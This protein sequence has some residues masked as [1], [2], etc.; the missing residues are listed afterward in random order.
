MQNLIYIIRIA[1]SLLL[2]VLLG[3]CGDVAKSIEI[4][5]KT[6]DMPV[7]EVKIASLPVDYS[8]TGSVVS[9]QRIDVSSRATGYIRKILVLEGQQVSKGQTL[10][11]LDES[12]VEGAIREAETVV[13]TAKLV[14]QD[15]E[16]D[17]KRYSDLY[18]RGSVSES[19][20]RK[21]RLFRDRAQYTLSQA[22]TSLK[23]AISQREYIKISSQ[24]TGVVVSRHSREGDLATPG[25]SIL[26]IESSQGLLFDTYVAESQISKIH[27]GDTALVS[28]DAL[29]KTFKGVIARV[30][31]AGDPLTRRYK[32]KIALPAHEGLLSGMFGRVHFT[33]ETRT[34]PV[35][36]SKALIE[37]GGLQGVF[38]V[39]DKNKAYFRWLQLGVKKMDIIEVRAGLEGGEL[40]LVREISQLREGDIIHNQQDGLEN[41]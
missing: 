41:E 13:N 38:V 15:A 25:S 31:P 29:H 14:V 33:L 28:I 21:T 34:S 12:D 8:S 36:P 7:A 26:T 20:I 9:D 35:I 5:P 19:K 37:R 4:E 30:V 1:T 27:R 16:I 23:I 24:I 32:V 11:M 18:K 2:I 3:S 6:W 17:L 22:K 10:V 39:N 40:I